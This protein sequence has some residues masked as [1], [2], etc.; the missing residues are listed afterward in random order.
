MGQ[1]N[2]EK[3]P[4]VESKGEDVTDSLES[5]DSSESLQSLVELEEEKRTTKSIK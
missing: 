3:V 5:S 2:R 1:K 4:L